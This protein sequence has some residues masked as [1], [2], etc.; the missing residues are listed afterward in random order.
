MKKNFHLFRKF[1]F[2]EVQD[3]LFITTTHTGAV[4]V[5]ASGT[6]YGFFSF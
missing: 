1:K 6:V 5:V 4:K 3:T 2:S